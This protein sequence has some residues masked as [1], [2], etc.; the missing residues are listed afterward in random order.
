MIAATSP[1]QRPRGAKLLVVRADGELVHAPRSSFVEFLSRGDLVIANDAA[2]LPAS[3]HGVHLRSGRTIEVRLAGHL[4]PVSCRRAALRVRFKITRS[5][6]LQ[7]C[8]RGGWQ[9]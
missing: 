9:A 2:T 1:I 3:L 6:A 7:G 4:P 5:A 8:P